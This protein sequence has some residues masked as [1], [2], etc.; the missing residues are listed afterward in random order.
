MKNVV[1]VFSVHILSDLSYSATLRQSASILKNDWNDSGLPGI[2]L[3]SCMLKA[4]LKKAPAHVAVETLATHILAYV[5]S[6]EFL[7]PNE[8]RQRSCMADI[9]SANEKRSN[10]LLDLYK[11]LD[12]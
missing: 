8:R 10:E 9:Y 11:A 2:F 12:N 1:A 7:P 4:T 5:I 6:S 3:L